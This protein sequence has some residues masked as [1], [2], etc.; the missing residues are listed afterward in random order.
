MTAVTLQDL[1]VA[2]EL[3][4]KLQQD[5]EG[6]EL[7]LKQTKEALRSQSQEIIPNMMTEVG[8]ETLTLAGG[9]SVSIKDEYYAKIPE[10]SDDAFDWLRQNNYDGIIKTQ[11]VAD[12]G[13]G[14]DE[15][16][17]EAIQVLTELG[18]FTKSN[19]FVHPQTLKAF[20]KEQLTKGSDL[21]LEAF[22]AGSVKT[23]V[24]VKQ[25]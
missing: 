23:S 15:K 8:I 16:A 2:A 4:L 22:G 5:V 19:S 9:Y 17:N 14:E 21:P 1:I 3:Q 6:L 12:F 13:K 25:K 7:S 10:N 11:V 18:I 24:I 20:V